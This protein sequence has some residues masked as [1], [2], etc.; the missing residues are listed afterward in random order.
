MFHVKEGN[1]AKTRAEQ[2]LH[3]VPVGVEQV[4]DADH[5]VRI[6]R[7]FRENAVCLVI[8][9]AAQHQ[10]DAADLPRIA[11]EEAAVGEA[12]RDDLV[13]Q[14]AQALQHEAAGLLPEVHVAVDVAQL[15]HQ[16]REFR[17]LPVV[18]VQR[19]QQQVELLHR[20][21]LPGVQLRADALQLGRG[22][23][24]ADLLQ[25][26]DLRFKVVVEAA[27]G[28]GQRVQ[29][30][31]NGRLVVALLKE[32]LLGGSEDGIPAQFTLLHG[33]AASFGR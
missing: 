3:G 9:V 30:V 17:R 12:R 10:D 25:Q 6:V 4:H 22:A 32:Q 20:I 26:R 27:L 11:G 14:R 21:E 15:Q 31:L 7:V 2:V 13:H 19:S 33:Q 24:A 16:R 8:D 29:D 18:Q 5:A 28:D 1:C 23:L